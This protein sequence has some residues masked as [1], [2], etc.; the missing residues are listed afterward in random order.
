MPNINEITAAA[1]RLLK[2]DTALN[3][4][5][6][7]Y[8]GA[9]RPARA[10]NP[11]ATVEA[12]RMEPGE[13]EGIWMCDLVV[14]VYADL[15]ADGAPDCEALED[16]GERVRTALGDAELEL[17]GAKMLPLFE[18]GTSAPEWQAAHDREAWQEYVFGL[19]FVCFG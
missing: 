6:T 3:G 16:M 4:M 11:V 5:C 15:L 12:R 18:G 9:K 2:E 7:V 10:R 1:Y 17:P 13:G 14:T 19:V 8:R